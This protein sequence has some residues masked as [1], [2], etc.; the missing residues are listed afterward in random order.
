MQKVLKKLKKEKFDLVRAFNLP[1]GAFCYGIRPEAL[2]IICEMKNTKYTANWEKYFTRTKKFKVADLKIPK[3]HICR[4]LRITLDYNEDFSLIKKIF[5]SL[6]KEKKIFNLTDILKLIKH[7]PK[8]TAINSFRSSDYIK[9]YKSETKLKLKNK[10]N[11]L[12]VRKP[13]YKEFINFIK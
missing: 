8:L 9:N 10:F 13:I 6:Y 3:K 1:H 2:K 7:N 5:K 11:Y 4:E 12:R